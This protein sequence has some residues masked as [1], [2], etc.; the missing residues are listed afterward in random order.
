MSCSCQRAHEPQSILG[1]E[2]CK[3]SCARRYCK[4]RSL[5][6]RIKRVLVGFGPCNT[7]LLAT[8]LYSM[9][10]YST[11]RYCSILFT[12]L[13]YSALLCSTV[14]FTTLLY[15]TL[16]FATLLYS[17]LLYSALLYASVLYSTLL[18]A[19]VLYS[20]LL[21]SMLLYFIYATLC[22]PTLLYALLTN[23]FVVYLD[24]YKVYRIRCF[25]N[26]FWQ[27]KLKHRHARRAGVIFLWI[28]PLEVANGAYQSI[29]KP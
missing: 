4:V 11:I 1:F 23:W 19:T 8:L 22:Y 28:K 27:T 16:L 2:F 21:Y 17:T 14:L 15:S 13:L 25:I 9:L 6:L 3:I 24:L 12:T 20:T 5:C 29:V 26:Y 18:Y 10:M 7:L